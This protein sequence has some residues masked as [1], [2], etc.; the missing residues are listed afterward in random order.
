MKEKNEKIN[1][2]TATTLKKRKWLN[3]IKNLIGQEIA[4]VQEPSPSTTSSTKP[5]GKST[6]RRKRRLNAKYREVS[7]TEAVQKHPSVVSL[8]QQISSERK[9]R[10]ATEHESEQLKGQLVA[11]QQTEYKLQKMKDIQTQIGK[12]CGVVGQLTMN[13]AELQQKIDTYQKEIEN[14]GA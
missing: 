9:A 1:V 14:Y 10:E 4:I 5:P 13:N 11:F 3:M 8:R 12:L 6:M 2:S 7:R